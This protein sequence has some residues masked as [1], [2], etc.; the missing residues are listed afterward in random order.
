[1]D[2]PLKGSIVYADVRSRDGKANYSASTRD[3]LTA[4]GADA[5]TTLTPECTHVVFKDGKIST[6][7]LAAK[8]GV[9]LVSVLWVE[10]CRTHGEWRDESDF[11]VNDDKIDTPIALKKARV[12]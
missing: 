11:F 8:F 10:S 3:Q 12:S 9:K 7:S 6:L 1:M 2:G 5:R 4:L